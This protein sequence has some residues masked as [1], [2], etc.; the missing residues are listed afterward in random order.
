MEYVYKLNLPPLNMILRE[1]VVDRYERSY[2]HP[3]FTTHDPSEL[4]KPEFLSINGF[5]WDLA[6]D[7]YKPTNYTGIVHIDIS[8][9]TQCAW[10]INWIYN[11]SGAIN[12]WHSE[13]ISPTRL[14][15]AAAGGKPLWNYPTDIPYDISYHMEPGVYLVNAS[16]PHQPV[17]FGSRHCISVRCTSSY[18][19][20][21]ENV[22]DKFSD[23]IL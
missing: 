17:S 19:L 12:Y 4:L 21:W 7:F 15:P 16:I 3:K 10:G 1:D 2:D 6:I 22:V 8:D 5:E 9:T 18:N 20:L 23:Y 14:V 11:A 13:N